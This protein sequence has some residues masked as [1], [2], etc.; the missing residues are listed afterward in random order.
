MTPTTKK[1][2]GTLTVLFC[3]TVFSGQQRPRKPATQPQRGTTKT[4]Q[5]VTQ[6]T[7]PPATQ[8]EIPQQT[9]AE[10]PLFYMKPDDFKFPPPPQGQRSTAPQTSILVGNPK[11]DGL[12]VS[13]TRI[14]KG[15]QVIPHTH[16]DSRTIV[17][18]SGT[19]YYGIGEEF[20]AK[21]L[22]ALPPGSFYTEPAGV[23][24]Y[25][26]AKDDEVIV[27]TTAIGPSSTQ[28]IPDKEPQ[29]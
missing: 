1:F 16:G 25:T 20:D 11:Q 3:V 12:Y 19:Y 15:K 18:L 14:P 24:H 2:L 27:Q 5:P 26:W 7:K 13:R 8:P 28:I 6:P 29:K 17:V 9:Q 22:I 10:M 21:K 4:A 23:P